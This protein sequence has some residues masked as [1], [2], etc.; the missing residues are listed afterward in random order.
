MKEEASS[1]TE[2]TSMKIK[3][4]SPLLGSKIPL[5]AYATPGAAAFDLHACIEEPITL[6]P[7]ERTLIPCG[8]AM[9]LEDSGLVALIFAR[10]GLACKKGISL[11]NSV[12][13]VDSDYR[14][15]VM[16]CLVNT[17]HEPYVIEAGER[18]AQMGIFPVALA[19]FS[20]CDEL[21]DTVRGSGGFGSTGK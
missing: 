6:Q 12:G 13:V 10:S 3:K 16:V 14:G 17:G 5:P 18:I 1:M 15:E 4:L 7:G 9:A 8:F 21:P 11:A 19:E 20:L 2:K